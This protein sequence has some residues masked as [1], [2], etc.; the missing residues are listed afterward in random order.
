[1]TCCSCTAIS[2]VAVVCLV[3]IAYAH[4]V[5]KGVLTLPHAATQGGTWKVCWRTKSPSEHDL[6]I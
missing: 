2:S 4:P 5:G 3:S 1:M 6:Y